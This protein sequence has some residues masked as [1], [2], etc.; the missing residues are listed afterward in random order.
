MF[1]RLILLFTILPILE[2]FILLQIGTKIGAFSTVLIVI[3]T[4]IIG[5]SL[6]RLQ[7]INTIR[8]IRQSLSEGKIPA[9]ELLD[10]FLIFIAGLLL[11]TPGLLTDLT[12]FLLLIPISRNKLKLWIKKKMQQ[13]INRSGGPV[14]FKIGF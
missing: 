8:R 12:G 4:A 3:G 13:W 14:N 10:G 2:L 6:A 11:V 9:E 7:G 5:A 1:A